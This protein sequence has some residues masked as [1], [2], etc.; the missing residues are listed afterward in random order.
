[1][2]QDEHD[3]GTASYLLPEFSLIDRIFRRNQRNT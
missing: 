1:M 2:F 3:A